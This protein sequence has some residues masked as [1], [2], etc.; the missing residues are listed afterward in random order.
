[1]SDTLS[2][3]VK[4]SLEWLFQDVDDLT[5]ISDVSKLAFKHSF[6]DGIAADE[7]DVLWHDERTLA[8]AANDDLDLTALVRTIFG[9]VLTVTF[10]KIKALL[11]INT[12]AVAGE[13]LRI[14]AAASNAWIGPFG[15]S[16]HTLDVP[17]DSSVLLVNRKDGWS[18][19]DGSSDVLRIANNGTG[20]ITYRIVM[21]GTSS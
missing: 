16:T 15:A 4:A 17:A 2:V 19:G 12:Q 21:V 11:V 3:D 13:D 18:V 14:G 5:T 20:D 10:A 9:S 8:A 7:A 1:M 6:V